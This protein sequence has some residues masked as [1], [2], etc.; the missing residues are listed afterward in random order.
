MKKSKL[1]VKKRKTFG[2]KVKKL[3]DQGILPANIYGKGIQSKAVQINLKEFDKIYKEVGETGVVNLK[4]EGEKK[5]RPVLIHSPQRHPVS[6][7][8]LHADFHQIS[9]KEKTTVEVPV[10]LIGEAPAEKEKIG[11][12]V[13]LLDSLEVEAL[14][15]DL[16]EKLEVD[17]SNLKAIDDAVKV[18]DIKIDKKKIKILTSENEIVAKIESLAKEEAPA[19]EVKPE[20]EVSEEEKTEEEKTEEAKTEEVKPEEEVK[21]SGKE[22]E[23]KPGK[24]PKKKEKKS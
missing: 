23:K 11:I 2:R 6:D 20:E 12:L 15:A 22:E 5:T 13:T 14:P 4:V 3:R 9:L 24:K 21:K 8:F 1:E 18:F 10:E 7:F 16:P 17:I 19:E